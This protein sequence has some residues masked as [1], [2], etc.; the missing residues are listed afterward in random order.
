MHWID[1]E[2]L[3]FLRQGMLAPIGDAP[4]YVSNKV[5]TKRPRRF[6]LAMNAASNS[7]ATD[8]L[9]TSLASS[10]SDHARTKGKSF[11]RPL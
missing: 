9:T 4:H 10:A 1:F 7:G 11:S 5:A 2:P 3:W 6:R 8:P